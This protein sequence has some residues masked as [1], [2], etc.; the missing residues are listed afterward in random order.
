MPVATDT[1]PPPS[2]VALDIRRIGPWRLFCASYR[3]LQHVDDGSP[4]QDAFALTDAGA[5]LNIAV[6]DGLGSANLSHIGA[7]MA[8]DRG[9]AMLS[10]APPNGPDDFQSIYQAIQRELFQHADKARRAVERRLA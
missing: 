8:C 10:H 5:A 7:Q 4:R 3:G 9:V 2:D 1:V 6:A